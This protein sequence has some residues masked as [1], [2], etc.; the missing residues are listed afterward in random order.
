MALKSGFWNALP[1]D[2]GNYDR[3]YNGDDFSNAFSYV[4]GNGVV[5]TNDGH[6]MEVT[7]AIVSGSNYGLTVKAGF[8]WINGKWFE[9]STD[10]TTTLGSIAAPTQG[11]KRYDRIVVRRCSNIVGDNNREFILTVIKGTESI[12]TPTKPEIVRNETYYDICLAN[13]LINRGDT[14]TISIE[15]RRPNGDGYKVDPNV[16]GWVNG[17]FGEN[18]EQKMKSME[19]A[20]NK[21]LNT[22]QDRA[23]DWVDNNSLTKTTVYR[24]II[25][26][27]ATGNT[28]NVGVNSYNPESDDLA[29]YVNGYQEFETAD[30]TRSGTTVTFK[31]NKTAGTEIAFEVTKSLDGLGL[32]DAAA[33]IEAYQV[34]LESINDY[35]ETFNYKCNGTTDNVQLSTIVNNFLKGNLSDYSIKKIMVHGT[36]GI[37]G[38]KSGTGATTNA[39]KW[40]DFT[41]ADSSGRKVILDFSNC[42][43]INFPIGTGTN[44]ILFFCGTNNIKIQNINFL[45]QQTGSNTTITGINGSGEIVFENCRGWIDTYNAVVFAKRGTFNDCRLNCISRNGTCS[46][47]YPS[48]ADYV[49]VNGGEYYA[50]TVN[51]TYSTIVYHGTSDTASATVLNSVRMP[52]AERSGYSQT[53]AVRVNH[54]YISMLNCITALSVSTTDSVKSSIVGTIPLSK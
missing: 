8:G 20:V 54:G 33:T 42:S 31:T 48:S 14:I 2:A 22:L 36:F 16:C 4:I 45:A 3:K 39:Y 13:I 43:E 25:T 52:T 30:W 5:N 50:Y 1:D 40:F 24:N 9:N 10:D 32:N 35:I 27:S 28:F 47:F 41:E 53:N 17:Y 51:G 19:T 49:I 26:V 44:N 15:D 37:T 12:E 38:A 34:E 23:D 46:I 6:S 29:I 11:R 21:Q 18:F 7:N